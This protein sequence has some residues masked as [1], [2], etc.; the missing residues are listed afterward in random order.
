MRCC[1]LKGAELLSSYLSD[2]SVKTWYICHVVA[3]TSRTLTTSL[4][5]LVLLFHASIELNLVAEYLRFQ[6]GVIESQRK[7]T[8]LNDGTRIIYGGC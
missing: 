6:Y 7:S 2:S 8:L 1:S 4:I 5:L 3:S